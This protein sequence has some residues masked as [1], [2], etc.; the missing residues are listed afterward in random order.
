MSDDKK[1]REKLEDLKIREAR[2]AENVKGGV[3]PID[4]K[5]T[6]TS[7]KPFGPIDS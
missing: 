4:S 6:T 5:T 7:P 2:E 3:G 1:N